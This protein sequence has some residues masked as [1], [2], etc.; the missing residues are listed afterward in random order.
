M[1]KEKENQGRR[2]R[3][4]SQVVILFVIAVLVSGIITFLVQGTISKTAILRQ[5]EE[6]TSE[7]GDEVEAAIREYPASDR[8]LFYWYTHAQKMDIE[9]DVGYG[10]GTKTEEK[11]RTLSAR[12]P[13]LELKYVTDAQMEGMNPEDQK[14]YAEI[15]YTWLIA[16]LNQIKT[17]YHFD[18][19]FCVV[20]DETYEKQF[21]LLSAA[22]PG[23]KRGIEYLEVYPLGH[24][25]TV[26]EDQTKAMQ[27]AKANT[28]YLA[29]AGIY[30]DYYTFLGE[31]E[32]H[33]VFI[34]LTYNLSG[35]QA[36]AASQAR[37]ETLYAMLFQIILSL[38][39]LLLVYRV[40]LQPLR[41]VQKN[42]RLYK[43][44][45]DSLAIRE[46]M[47]EVRSHNEIGDLSNDVTEL[48]F[49]MDN[50][51]G[52]IETITA[53]KQRVSTELSMATRI[54]ASMLPHIF[55]PFPGRSEF[56]I[57]ASMDPAKEVGGDFYD[58]FLIDDDH[59]G[60]V[61][62]DV[63]GKGVPAALFMMA[64]K[65][66]LQSCA[67]LGGSPAEILTKTNEAICS[68]NQ[69]ELFVTVWLG[70]LEISTGKI[71]AANAGHE[72]PIIQKTPGGPLELF[73]D[74]HGFVIGGMPGT[75]YREYELQLTPGTKLFLYTDGV[76]EATDG[77]EE[78]FGN[79]RML[80][81]LNEEPDAEPCRVLRNVRRAVDNFV[82]DAEQFDDLTMLCLEYRGQKTEFPPE[83]DKTKEEDGTKTA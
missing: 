30:V 58:F 23:A 21:F 1:K 82:K 73:Q 16:R 61:M 10:A 48:A 29:N 2:I 64:S 28:S 13:D 12:Y 76:P 55:P 18:F 78:M 81:A 53:E 75:K 20:A 56:D 74:R 71:K 72:Y 39:C 49:E 50:Y 31:V 24:I 60:I 5:T 42:I 22:E 3:L 59:L 4:I 54:Q 46:G 67:M 79:E 52:E 17:A 14:L 19:L 41:K 68:N 40:V 80:A 45:K 66:I 35:L 38:I 83:A 43:E 33:P 37:R 69:E 62:A 63:S 15:V 44:N 8:L 11:C 32:G 77:E 9:Y 26:G 65:I 36:S 6:R 57:Y 34:G 25:V 51:I 27:S 7:I 47:K 70:I